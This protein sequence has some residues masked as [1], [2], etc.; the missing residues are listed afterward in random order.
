MKEIDLE[1]PKNCVVNLVKK[2]KRNMTRRNDQVMRQ[3]NIS[4]G[5][6]SILTAIYNHQDLKASQLVHIFEMEK[7]TI[8]R[9]LKILETKKLIEFDKQS[10]GR[11]KAICITEKGRGTYEKAYLEWQKLQEKTIKC[12]GK[13]NYNSLLDINSKLIDADFL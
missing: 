10:K 11:G 13:Q 2:I 9:E 5:H 3:F 1:N 7:S 4:S 6:F 8:S 12:I